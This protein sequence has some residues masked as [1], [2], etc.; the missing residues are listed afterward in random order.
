MKILTI[1]ALSVLS[2]GTFAQ[3]EAIYYPDTGAVHIPKLQVLGDSSGKSY[4]IDLKNTKDSNFSVLSVVP[5]MSTAPSRN[6]QV[7][8]RPYFLVEGMQASPLKTQLE[9]CGN[10]AFRKTDFSVGHRGAGLQFPEHTKESYMAAA[11][12]GAGLIECDV[13]FTKDKQLVCRHSQCDLHT[14]T[15]ILDTP[16]GAKCSTPF[17]PANSA[18]GKAASAKCCT[19]DIT[20]SEFK[21]L[22]G[23]MDA[24]N[25][26]ATTVAQYLGGTPNWRTD[27]YSSCGTL[28]SH[29]ESIQLF[30]Q[31]DVK[32]IPELK[33]A[34]VTMPYEGTYTQEQY[35][36]QMI[37][38][39]KAA[40]VSADRVFP[41]SFNLA[42]VLYWIKN[43]PSFGNQ[44]LFLDEIEAFDV[45]K[46][47]ASTAQLPDLVAK[48]VKYIGPPTWLL[49]SLDSN[50][51]IVPSD[52][53][54]KAKA[55]G[56]NMITWTLERSGLL[57]TGGGWYYQSVN[58]AIHNDSDAMEFLN[59][60]SK[61]I[62]IKGIFSDWPGTVTYYANCMGL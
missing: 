1:L 55:L 46:V 36:Q 16:L 45:A 60:L 37:D 47:A 11:R 56:L 39:Y 12:M 35:A 29:A 62:G 41:Q 9:Q 54:I 31:L 59:L 20:Y 33:A 26:Q 40:G 30:K 38:E 18:T 13:T 44:A 15:N 51:R 42:D 48:G 5:N 23:K 3:D 58:S 2:S 10:L 17:T 19:S 57:K 53:A 24:S 49:V 21:N 27:L 22:C 61:D 7:G 50:Q 25:S 4:S 52:Y 8:P 43:E 28:M 34:S 6:V 14:T 32:M